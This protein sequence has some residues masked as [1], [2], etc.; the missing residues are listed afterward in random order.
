MGTKRFSPTRKLNKTNISNVPTGKPIVYRLLSKGGDNLYTGS[1]K[2]LRSQERLQEHMPGGPDPIPGASSFQV[3]QKESIKKA[4]Q[5]EK[6]I[7]E[8]EKPKYNKT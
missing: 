7:I 6:R 8:K 2:R 4:Q 3:K 1:A 5:E